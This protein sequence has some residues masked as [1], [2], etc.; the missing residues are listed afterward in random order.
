MFGWSISA[1]ACRS[2]SNRA[3]TCRVSMPGLMTFSATLRRTGCSARPC[4]RRPCP[5]RRSAPAA[6]TGR[7]CRRAA[8]AAESSGLPLPA[9]APRRAG[10]GGRRSRT[11]VPGESR[12]AAGVEMIGH[13]LFHSPFQIRVAPARPLDDIRCS[14]S[15]GDVHGGGEDGFDLSDLLVRASSSQVSHSFRSPTPSI[16]AEINDVFRGLSCTNYP[17]R[18]GPVHRTPPALRA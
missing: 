3:M 1:S 10:G 5:L 17:T 12:E 9:V 2:A 6:C 11:A 4:R 18:R 15:S 13:Q 16:S 8:L 14:A 7:R